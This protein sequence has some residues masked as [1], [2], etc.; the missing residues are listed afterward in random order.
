MNRTFGLLFY[1]KK[2]RVDANG[3][4]PIYLRITIDG[5]RTE[6]STKRSVAISKWNTSANKA[7]GRTGDVRELN[8]YLDT[9]QAK[10]YECERD[11]I[12]DNK[13][14]TVETIKNK[15]L[16]IEEKQRTVLSIF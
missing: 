5:R 4:S 15:L 12:Q 1:L 11:L 2:N 13:L 8:A 7:V 9:L 16:G 10:V 14:V 3:K 6:I